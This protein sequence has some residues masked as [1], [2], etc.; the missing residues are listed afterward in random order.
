MRNLLAAS[1]FGLLASLSAAV[2]AAEP[3]FEV[4]RLDPSLT[5]PAAEDV[6]HGRLDDRFLP[7][8]GTRSLPRANDYWLRLTLPEAFE[9]R[10]VATVKVRKGRNMDAEL[11]VM[12]HGSPVAL[13]LASYVPGFTGAQDA[14]YILPAGLAAGQAVYVHATSNSPGAT[15]MRFS[16]STL[17]D[18]L[19]VAADHARMIALS[20]GALMA[21]AVAALLIWFVLS[22]RLL[23]LYATLFAL[24]ALY[25]A[26]LSGQGFEWPILSLALPVIGYSWNVVAAFMGAVACLFVREIAELQRFSPRVHSL[27]GWFAVIFVVLAFANFADLIGLGEIVVAIGNLVFVISAVTTLV[28]AFL[29][30]RRDNRAAGWFLVAWGLLETLTIATALHLLF[31]REDGESALLL[32]YALPGSMVAAAVLIALGVADR[33]RDQRLALTDAERRAQSDALTGVLNRRSLL[34]R[35]DSACLR[36]RARGLPIALLFIDLDHFKQINDTHGHPAGDACLKAI[37][38]PIQAELRQ[39]DVIGRYGGEEFVVILSSAD[40]AAAQP[41]A[42]RIRQRVAEISVPGFGAAIHLTCSI[43]IATSDMLGVWGEHL[44]ARADEAVYAAKRCGR[45]CV[46]IAAPTPVAA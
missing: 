19:T 8:S 3:A 42:E 43:G 6:T 41:I 44:I 22:D 4:R 1:L 2:F 32:Y 7:A 20:F 46:Q 35:L 16:T 34:E 14:I 25:I 39:S 31:S 37:I 9:P 38:G 40:A 13:R 21:M 23:I 33:L 27:F 28:V 12:D 26:Y 15:G 30:W 36:A 24:Q 5:A 17:P 11:F 29:A 10:E 18:T 45:N